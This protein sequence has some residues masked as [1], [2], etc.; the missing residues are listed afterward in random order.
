MG[1]HPFLLRSVFGMAPHASQE[2]VDSIGLVRSQ[3]LSLPTENGRI[4]ISLNMGLCASPRNPALFILLEE[5]GISHV[6][7]SW[8]DIFRT[9]KAMANLGWTPL[10]ISP[11]YYLDLQ[12]RFGLGAEALKKMK[13]FG[14][15]YDADISGGEFFHFFTATVEDDLHFE[16]VQRIG[17][18]EGFGEVNSA[19]RISAQLQS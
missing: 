14:I 19:A 2:A 15:L 3:A 10:P 9:A 11:N 1:Q 17:G 12:A 7:C 18:Y 6:V 8:D 5:G 13:Q 4:R 16:I